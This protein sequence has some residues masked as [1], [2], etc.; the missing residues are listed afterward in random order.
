MNNSRSAVVFLVLHSRVKFLCSDFVLFLRRTSSLAKAFDLCAWASYR[1]LSS[2]IAAF[3]LH[4]STHFVPLCCLAMPFLL[5]SNASCF[6]NFSRSLASCLKIFS[7]SSAWCSASW[8]WHCS[9]AKVL[10]DSVA[11][12][13]AV[14]SATANHLC[15]GCS[16]W[17]CCRSR[18]TRK[19][20][21]YYIIA[22]KDQSLILITNFRYLIFWVMW[23]HQSGRARNRNGPNPA[24]YF[25]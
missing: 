3:P 1:S 24:V 16:Q 17:R 20:G 19:Y 8:R 25:Y 7:F 22:R 4:S 10:V 13:W 23:G 15:R 6:S 21:K 2:R 18:Y 14:T 11:I 12:A 5:L 9:W